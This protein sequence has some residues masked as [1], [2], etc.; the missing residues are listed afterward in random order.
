MNHVANNFSLFTVGAAQNIGYFKPMGTH[1]KLVKMFKR[2][3]VSFLCKDGLGKDESNKH[4][5]KLTQCK[6]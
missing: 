3:D 5:S 1:W 4:A 6:S 2:K